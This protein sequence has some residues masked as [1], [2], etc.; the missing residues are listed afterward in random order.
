MKTI[1]KAILLLSILVVGNSFVFAAKKKVQNNSETTEDSANVQQEAV[2]KPKLSP[3]ELIKLR[4]EWD[5][6]LKEAA[7]EIAANPPQFELHYFNEIKFRALTETDYEN[8]TISL[9]VTIPYLKQ[10]SGFENAGLAKSLLD[11]LHEIKESNNWGDKINDFPWTY[12]KDI[13]NNNWMIKANAKFV[14]KFNF[15]ISIVDQKQRIL[16]QRPITY[17]VFYDKQYSGFVMVSDNSSY[18]RSNGDYY[19]SE[20]DYLDFKISLKDVDLD[21]LSVRVENKGNQKLAI[22][23]AEEGAL[24]YLSYIDSLK[25]SPVLYRKVVG[26]SNGIGIPN[27]KKDITDNNYVFIDLS[28]TYNLNN[29]YPY[30]NRYGKEWIERFAQEYKEKYQWDGSDAAKE[31]KMTR[32][33]S[34][35]KSRLKVQYDLVINY[36]PSGSSLVLQ[37][38]LKEDYQ[39]KNKSYLK[40]KYQPSVSNDTDSVQKT[41]TTKQSASTS[42]NKTSGTTEYP[43]TVRKYYTSSD[44]LSRFSVAK[45]EYISFFDSTLS[46]TLKDLPEVLLHINSLLAK[47]E[48]AGYR[49]RIYK[50]QVTCEY[51]TSKDDV[52]VMLNKMGEALQKLDYSV[53]LR[54]SYFSDGIDC[55]YFKKCRCLV[56]IEG[57]YAATIPAQAFSGCTNLQELS[58]LEV[59]K[60]E[61]NVFEGCTSLKRVSVPKKMKKDVKKAYVDLIKNDVFLFF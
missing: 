9:D 59:K 12:A 10:I 5:K 4:S 31:I 27:N 18:A 16:A 42:N 50:F 11:E 46:V 34:V 53:A 30:T 28:D 23:P 43:V 17:M 60:I 49:N 48:N 24:R 20:E 57:L 38:K 2:E 39:E 56:T 29:L 40:Q 41:T 33:L 36:L 1:K 61:P 47:S 14:D 19:F 37:Q 55:D 26:N 35:E 51:G 13:G 7:E 15:I 3:T 6:K 8:E 25:T 58:I 54:M 22:L 32:D 21:K 52:K 44:E 45:G